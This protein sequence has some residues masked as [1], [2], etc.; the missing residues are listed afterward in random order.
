MVRGRER[1]AKGERWAGLGWAGLWLLTLLRQQQ[2]EAALQRHPLPGPLVVGRE[3]RRVRRL[4][5]LPVG[6]LLEGVEAVALRVE[7]VHEMHDGGGGCGGLLRL[8]DRWVGRGIEEPAAA[9]VV[10]VGN[11]CRIPNERGEWN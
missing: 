7:R 5:D 8:I 9:V 3:A 1:R 2:A 4:G 10:E 11:R 6:D